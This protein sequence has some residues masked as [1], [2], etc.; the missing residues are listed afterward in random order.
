MAPRYD[1]GQ[2]V[3]VKPADEPEQTPRDSDLH[4]YAG[5]VGEIKDYFWISPREGEVFYI[6]TVHVET[7]PRELALHEDEIEP[8]LG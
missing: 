5:V 7:G 1:V 8:F 3:R 4:P 6:Y 2:K